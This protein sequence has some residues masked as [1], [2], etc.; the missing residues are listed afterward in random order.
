MG[1]EL[2]ECLQ[3]SVN[4]TLTPRSV[5][6]VT[7]SDLQPTQLQA[8]FQVTHVEGRAVLS[9]EDLAL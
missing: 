8:D 9:Q 7:P 3:Y 4:C 2:N 5:A 6:S 1:I